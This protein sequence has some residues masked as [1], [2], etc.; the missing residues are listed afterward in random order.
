MSADN[1]YAEENLWSLY[2]DI[3]NR[4]VTPLRQICQNRMQGMDSFMV[5]LNLERSARDA[6][7]IADA[8]EDKDGSK[9][10]VKKARKVANVLEHWSDRPKEVKKLV[11]SAYK[12][13]YKDTNGSSTSG[14]S[15]CDDCPYEETPEGRSCWG[16]HLPIKVYEK[17]ERQYDENQYKDQIQD[18]GQ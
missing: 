9:H 16:C 4:R 11:L 10:A 17:M 3:G 5:T 7:S 8:I 15:G 13:E 12:S 2:G 18:K 14:Y 1:R 6:D